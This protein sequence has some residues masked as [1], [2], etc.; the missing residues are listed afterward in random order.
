MNKDEVLRLYDRYAQDVVQD[1]FLK[2]LAKNR[3]VLP[4]KEKSYILAVTAN[5][6]RDIIRLHGAGAKDTQPATT[7][8]KSCNDHQEDMPVN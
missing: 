5:R 2:L 7:R 1:V 6:C 8:F 3:S 4:G